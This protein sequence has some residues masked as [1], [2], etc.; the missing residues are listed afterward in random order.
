MGPVNRIREW[1]DAMPK[2]YWIAQVSVDDPDAY[3]A[4]RAANAAAFAKYGARFL[5][6]G[7]EPDLREGQMR[8]RLVVIEFADLDT[9][10]ACYDS[11]EYQAA[12]RLR[13]PCSTADLAIV[14]GYDP[15]K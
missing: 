7:A 5:V 12:L 13:Q 4:Y 8:P 11:P 15:E 1:G 2:A 6:R 14:P 3:E 9:A 10:R